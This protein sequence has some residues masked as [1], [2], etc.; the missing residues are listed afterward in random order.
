MKIAIPTFGTRVS[1]RF[2]C[3]Q[4]IAVVTVGEGCL[5]DRQELAASDWPPHE[6][7]HRLLEVGVDTVICGGIDRWSVMRLQSAGVTIYGWV[8]GE[9]GDALAALLKGDLDDE[10]AMHGDGRCRCRRFAGDK[11]EGRSQPVS[12]QGVKGRGGGGRHGRGRLER[13]Q[14]TQ[15]KLVSTG[16]QLMSSKENGTNN[17]RVIAIPVANGRLCMHFGHCEQFALLDVDTEAKEI[18]KSRQIDPPPHQPGLLPR[19]LHEQGVKL[20][21]AGGMGGRAKGIFAEKGI[22]VL[23][24][25]PAESPDTLARS[26]LD[27]TL[28]SG[29][30]TCDH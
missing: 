16:G 12:P 26:Y 3:A 20:V 28:Q 21:I 6:R 4:E 27:G 15:N 8:S 23:I 30:N 9:V 7:I 19:W 1:P 2:D 13:D 14:A 11:G 22:E 5:S 10:A 25:A 29:E 17:V 24:G 18:L